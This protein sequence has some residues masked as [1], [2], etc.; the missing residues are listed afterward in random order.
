MREPYTLAQSS[1]TGEKIYREDSDSGMA[2]ELWTT[3][4]G[5]TYFD[6]IKRDFIVIN[7]WEGWV[8]PL[9]RLAQ[10]LTNGEQFDRDDSDSGMAN[11]L[12]EFDKLI[13]F[14][15]KAEERPEV[16]ILDRY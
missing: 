12:G 11:E 8:W 2:G 15:L 1:I 5:T 6:I 13:E 7:H 3:A 4:V 9:I 14:R 10:N 16:I